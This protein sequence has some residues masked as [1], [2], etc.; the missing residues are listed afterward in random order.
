[1]DDVPEGSKYLD[2]WMHERVDFVTRCHCWMFMFDT[3][4]ARGS[5]FLLWGGA[6]QKKKSSGRGGA[7]VKLGAVRGGAVRDGAVSKIFE[8]GAE[9]GAHPCLMQ[10]GDTAL[11]CFRFCCPD[12]FCAATAADCAIAGH[13]YK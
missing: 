13:F 4:D 12:W 2:E 11:E 6:G 1:M 7:T 5:V 10:L 9:R 8:S 3:R